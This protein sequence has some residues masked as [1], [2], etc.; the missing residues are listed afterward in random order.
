MNEKP[1]G[2]VLRIEATVWVSADVAKF[3]AL[4]TTVSP[5]VSMI[6]PSVGFGW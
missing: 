6:T 4:I 5:C 2:I 1:R 3:A